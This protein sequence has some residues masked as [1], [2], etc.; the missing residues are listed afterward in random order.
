MLGHIKTFSYTWNKWACQSESQQETTDTDEDN[1]KGV[2]IKGLVTELWT[3]Y[4]ITTRSGWYL[5]AGKDRALLTSLSWKGQE[6]G[7]IVEIQRQ[8]RRELHSKSWEVS[9]SILQEI[10]RTKLISCP[11]S[12]L[13]KPNQT[14]EGKDTY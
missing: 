2:F 7:T 1:H 5:V 6:N 8:E 3:G 13:S 9:G 11:G 4:R 14:P 10:A 12:P